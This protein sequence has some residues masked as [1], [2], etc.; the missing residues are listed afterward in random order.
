VPILSARVTAVD[1]SP[2]GLTPGLSMSL[3]L[4]TAPTETRVAAVMLRAIVRIDP[5]ARGY[6]ARE[7]DALLP[8]FGPEPEW[9]RTMR[10]LLWARLATTVPAFV[11][12]TTVELL[13][14]VTSDLLF[15]PA[16]YLHAL[17]E[18]GV[19][20]RLVVEG[21]L[22]HE[23]DTGLQVA[24]APAVEAAADLPVATLRRA[25]DRHVGAGIG[26]VLATD[27][28]TRLDRYRAAHALGDLDQA[29]A[30]LLQEK[31]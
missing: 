11:G 22:F 29:V 10:P 20:L 15:G 5:L 31:T 19:P 28:F 13:L 16:R 27:T 26:V 8:L 2:A 23:T 3:E 21:S 18:G 17:V 4:S 7:R 9:P 12:T 25:I 24:L 14:P 1:V 6:G 30:R